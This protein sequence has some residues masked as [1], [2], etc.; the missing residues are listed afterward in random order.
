MCVCEL[1][2]SVT[3]SK[4]RPGKSHRGFMLVSGLFSPSHPEVALLHFLP[5]WSTGGGCAVSEVTNSVI[6]LPSQ[7]KKNLKTL[8]LQLLGRHRLLMR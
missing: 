3:V 8:P 6:A 5:I 1:N 4:D 7:Y 2:H